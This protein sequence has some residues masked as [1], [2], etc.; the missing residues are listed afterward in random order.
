MH[1]HHSLSLWL[2]PP[3]HPLLSGVTTGQ[4]GK[5]FSL[6]YFV[7]PP[8]CSFIHTLYLNPSRHICQVFYASACV[9]CVS[10]CM[11]SRTHTGARWGVGVGI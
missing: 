4:E 11:S 6:S 2:S 10:V 3:P 9:P 5:Y 7:M 1:F 8:R